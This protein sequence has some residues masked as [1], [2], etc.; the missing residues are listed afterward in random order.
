MATGK[1]IGRVEVSVGNVRFVDTEG[2]L[3]DSGYEGLMYE[4]EQIYSDDPDALFQI[5]YVELPESTAYDGIFR[6]LADGSVISGLD[7]NENMFGDDIDFMETAAGDAGPE[8]SSA[9]LEE[10]GTDEFDLLGF[11]RG[12][13]EAGLL[14]GATGAGEQSDADPFNDQPDVA[15]I[16][17]GD[18]DDVV[19]ESIDANGEDGT[20]DDVETTLTGTLSAIDGNVDDTHVFDTSSLIVTSDD[21][22]PAA[23]SI[24]SF[25]L[26][27]NEHGD[28]T[29]NSAD[30]EIVG[31][32]NALGAGETATLTFTYTATDDNPLTIQPNESDPG[33]YTIVVTG[34]NDQPVITD[35]NH[36]GEAEN[37]SWLI[38]A[39]SEPSGEDSGGK[40]SGE[41]EPGAD[42]SDIDGAS[43]EDINALF[44]VGEGSVEV[45]DLD[46]PS[47]EDYNPTDG[48]ALKITM[49]VEAGETVTFNW[50]F[51]DAEGYNTDED[52][53]AF[54]PATNSGYRDFS[55]VVIDGVVINLLADT[56]DEGDTNSGVFTYT[57][58][59][60]GVHEITF[61]VMN[62][63]DEVVDSSLEVTYVSGGTIVSTESVGHVEALNGSVIEGLDTFDIT[64]SLSPP[65]GED[66]EG[67][68]E[69]GQVFIAEHG[70]LNTLELEI[71]AGEDGPP[72]PPPPPGE[73]GPS[74]IQ[75]P[76]G[77]DGDSVV[78]VHIREL[79]A[80][81][82]NDITLGE[83]IYSSGE[84]TL[85]EI[86]GD[87]LSITNMGLELEVGQ[88][89]VIM[90]ESL[91]GTY[92]WEYNFNSDA[93][94]G[95]GMIATG[96]NDSSSDAAPSLADDIDLDDAY[97]F[98]DGDFSVRLTYGNGQQVIY[99]SHD[100]EDI[101]G[102]IDTQAD[103]TMVFTGVIDTV[104]DDD[105]NDTHAYELVDG[106][107]R[108]NGELV[109]Q[110]MVTVSFNE[111]SG[112]WEYR[113]EGDFN[114]IDKGETATITFDYVAIDDSDDNIAGDR[115]DLDIPHES[116]TSEAA[117]V[118]L[119][120]TGTN[121][122]PIVTDE[123]NIV[124]EESLLEVVIGKDEGGKESKDG[125]SL[126]GKELEDARYVGSVAD[127]VSDD[128]NND[129]GENTHTFAIDEGTLT[130]SLT[131]ANQAFLSLFDVNNLESFEQFVEGFTQ[132][133]LDMSILNID[134]DADVADSVTLATT[135]DIPQ[136]FI[137]VL[138]EYGI[139]NIAMA[140]DGTYSIQSPLFN[141][142]GASDSLTIGFDYRATDNAGVGE[143]NGLDELSESEAATVTLTI[144]GTNDQPVAYEADYSAL[145]SEL[146]D[147]AVGGINATFTA[148]LPGA[149]SGSVLHD[150]LSRSGLIGE[151]MDEDLL[152]AAT[153]TF[154]LADVDVTTD[155]EEREPGDG[156]DVVDATQTVVVVNED[157]TFSVTNPTFD[158]LA[159]G[160]TATIT[161]QYYI[162]DES[163][164]VATTDNAHESTQSDPV[165]VTVTITGTN[166]QP[167]IQNVGF[168][169]NESHDD[170]FY[171]NGEDDTQ[172]DSPVLLSRLDGI[173][174]AA[175]DDVN[176]THVF[177]VKD[178][179]ASQYY[180]HGNGGPGQNGDEGDIRFDMV[181]FYK[182]GSG[183]GSQDDSGPM[184]S[185][186]EDSGGNEPVG[187]KMMIASE[188]VDVHNLDVTKLTFFNNN[189]A[190]SQINFE[191]EGDFNALGVGE[192]ATIT[193]KYFANDKEGFGGHGGG[194]SG[195]DGSGSGSGGGEDIAPLDSPDG[196]RD[197]GPMTDENSHSEP[198]LVT[199]TIMG[200]NDQ[201]IIE[202]IETRNAL[203]TDLTAVTYG[204]DVDVLLTDIASDTAEGSAL[205]VVLDTA[206][207][208][209]VSFDWTFD[210]RDWDYMQDAAFV[211][212]DG[213]VTTLAD[214][215]IDANGTFSYEF[216]TAGEH[217][218][219]V[220]VLNNHDNQGYGGSSLLAIS[221][222]NGGELISE[223]TFGAVISNPDG[224]YGMSANSD[225]PVEDLEAF[226]DTQAVTY[227]NAVLTGNIDDMVDVTD[228]DDNDGYNYIA[229]DDLLVDGMN[230]SES[231][232]DHSDID[233]ITTP[234]RV[235][236]DANG[237]YTLVS[238]SFDKLGEGDSVEVTFIV[239]VQDDSGVGT[240][241]D[242]DESSFSEIKTVT[243]VINGTNDSPV[244][245]SITTD[246]NIM[247]T[248]LT[249]SPWGNTDKPE[250]SFLTGTL[251]AD[252]SDEDVNDSH[253]FVAFGPMNAL[254]VDNNGVITGNTKVA[255]DSDGNYSV[256]NPSF[257][258]LADGEEV[259]VSF[260][261]QVTD[262]TT[263]ADSGESA[264]SNMQTVT[265]TITGTNDQPHVKNVWMRVSEESLDPDIGSNENAVFEGTLTSTDEDTNN[266][267]PHYKIVGD[268]EVSQ[269]AVGIT[270]ADIS[271]ALANAG[272][273]GWN[274]S[275]D[276]TISSDKFNSL[277]EGEVLT[278]SFD[279]KA[280]DWEGF[281]T[282]GDGD[283]EA[284]HSNVK[285]VTLTI[286]GT[287]DVAIISP[288]IAT[289]N[290]VEDLPFTAQGF[291]AITDEDYG[292]AAFDTE[293]VANS[294][295]AY[296]TFTMFETGHWTYVLDPVA[297]QAV[298]AGGAVETFTVSSV[299]GSAS[300]LITINIYGNN[301]APVAIGETITVL[302]DSYSA[303]IAP[304]GVYDGMGP[305]YHVVQDSNGDYGINQ[306]G[307][308]WLVVPID[309]SSEIDSLGQNE[310]II[311]TFAHDVTSARISYT[312][313][314]SDDNA[315]YRL[316]LDGQPV[317]GKIY[318]QPNG[319]ILIN[320]GI[321]FDAIFIYAEQADGD[322]AFH[323]TDF[324]VSN[325]VGYYGYET[326]T[327][328]VIEEETLLA[329]DTDV[330]GDTLELG[331][332]D[333]NLYSAENGSV[334]GS[335]TIDGNGDV[336]V[337]PDSG[338][339]FGNSVNEFATFDY[340]VDDGNGGTATATATVNVRIGTLAE[341]VAYENVD[342]ALIVDNYDTLDLS[343][344]SNISVI[345]LGE[346]STVVGEDSINI[347]AADVLDASD[348]GMLVINSLDGDASDQVNVDSSLTQVDNHVG[349]DGTL[350]AQYTGEG[351]TLLIEIEDTITTDI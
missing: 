347:T 71:F 202:N 194:G 114:F 220:G 227:E 235:S 277:R 38:G 124:S 247:E 99:E 279:Y 217:T 4:G 230:I 118:T 127:N 248:D 69:Y 325:V 290:V 109:D 229:F 292:Q 295:T 286:I 256:F 44:Y 178:Y 108:I 168:T 322:N 312:N 213:V 336:Y 280:S 24:T 234:V 332:V 129:G 319:T 245:N 106:T 75:P 16:T 342:N 309:S 233:L 88:K 61:G 126:E 215:S 10:V 167:V 337:N 177:G 125:P 60:A 131:T 278:V 91:D 130:L 251:V 266:T 159:T 83:T 50:T 265:L 154:H 161:F 49:D 74:N 269:N 28:D 141:L 172:G 67:A 35:I 186:G 46:P 225:L 122:Q 6:V 282:T 21:I 163:G 79:V 195:S 40:D 176:N 310:Q 25:V 164:A 128:D 219:V 341:G 273:N 54:D 73:D 333:G 166:D 132:G 204:A 257:N 181:D 72:P 104:T 231:H 206:A 198:K 184:P 298:G 260:N 57:F 94:D 11:G 156:I 107:V 209:T 117:T 281:G 155:V 113:I 330:E 338:A 241:T 3:R 121:D 200:T 102:E 157:G 255:L 274:T 326:V 48:A 65:L 291:L 311:F 137:E 249:G 160:E 148:S 19:Y 214:G 327:P 165:E 328:F 346:D 82:G 120:L 294:S 205:K 315:S 299:D 270:A 45:D 303:A 287:N 246:T 140:E 32:F 59:D 262:G 350:Y 244:L 17:V 335:V 345:Q 43:K 197:E 34:T 349:A 23:I 53:S 142:L 7:G 37:P 307:L 87:I 86:G 226:I 189:G 18:G 288:I 31:N 135:V 13:D 263:G 183:G 297:S 308:D 95:A 240:G 188:D 151:D 100:S 320:H 343:N 253:E 268:V 51:N 242:N 293:Y 70:I 302:S 147:T 123:T 76:P 52:S 103:E 252:I 301:D 304:N 145:E 212:V 289:G 185:P 272:N 136:H 39:S 2:N 179:T 223:E 207:G 323:W 285:T 203:E 143:D 174:S 191:L 228:D 196:G 33:T 9:F 243:I 314:D 42:Y 334:V 340:T 237:N 29:P 271:V 26:T 201:P 173:L 331:L 222:T 110:S 284:S 236:L 97:V 133:N 62:D 30:F 300:Q 89:Y 210:L 111:E 192:T 232:D 90:I 180:G 1:V 258:K 105:V 306:N 116:D 296:G 254:V 138:Q 119:T 115:E 84:I 317:S 264:I 339:E 324:Q 96:T 8:G 275:G 64:D 305:N 187:V 20:Q 321:V 139:L 171:Q 78:I 152:D 63:D 239:Q 283:N 66:Y 85:D 98:S 193:F 150:I 351:A 250:N 276:Y 134:A 41:P 211:V 158:N 261:V 14:G 221:N 238:S 36:N 216:A 208:E 5:K 77:E 153:L 175:D 146:T 259:T 170:T 318:N 348:D 144:L 199:I 68:T 101:P 81:D 313:F 55:F 15:D 190:D 149:D 162:D 218:I 80:Q 22:D 56:F 93:L 92:Q 47:G 12:A 27:N 58:A 344:V 224:S 267:N 112:N 182:K 316:Y 169:A 329:N